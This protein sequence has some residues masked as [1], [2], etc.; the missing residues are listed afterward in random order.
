MP[1]R[2]THG[3][4][5]FGF[6]SKASWNVGNYK[7]ELEKI[8]QKR[9]TIGQICSFPSSFLSLE[10]HQISLPERFWCE[11][12]RCAAPA[13]ESQKLH[14]NGAQPNRQLGLGGFAGVSADS[15]LLLIH[16]VPDLLVFPVCSFSRFLVCLLFL[17]VSFSHT[18]PSSPHAPRKSAHYRPHPTPLNDQEPQN[19]EPKPKPQ[20]P[21]PKSQIPKL[22]FWTIPRQTSTPDPHLPSA[23]VEIPDSANNRVLFHQPTVVDQPGWGARIHAREVWPTPHS[24]RTKPQLHT[25]ASQ[26]QP[27]NL[28][29]PFAVVLPVLQ[30]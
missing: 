24:A 13:T 14:P 23:S 25:C 2:S 29:V 9:T 16:P 26:S 1:D 20:I 27:P 4:T 17:V 7:N 10:S 5:E 28:G 12:A 30:T 15:F 8:N 18:V 3:S 22:K 6:P 11:P 21:N 19:E